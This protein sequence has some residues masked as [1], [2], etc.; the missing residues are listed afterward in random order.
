MLK[1]NSMQD[2]KNIILLRLAVLWLL[3]CSPHGAWVW[4]RQEVGFRYK[5]YLKYLNVLAIV[6]IGVNLML[7]EQV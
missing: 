6:L 7:A 2:A 4:S 1:C 5:T 3:R